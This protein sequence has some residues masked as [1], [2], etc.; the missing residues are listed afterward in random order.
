MKKIIILLF[1]PALLFISKSYCQNNNAFEISKNLEI[2]ADVFKQLNNNYV[3]EIKPG[4]LTKTAIDA[5]LETLDPYTVYKSES[6][7]EDFRFM[8]TGQYGG[9]GALIQKHD[10]FVVISEPYKNF[11]ADKAGIKAGDKIL[12][13][14]GHDAKNLSTSEVSEMLKGQPG[15]EFILCV[16]RYGEEKPLNIPVNREK[17]QIDDIPYYGMANDHI[18][19]I[20]LS[21]FTQHAASHVKNAFL[22]LKSNN[23]LE[24]IIL[25]LRG[26][27][28]G[29]LNEAV[30]LVNIWVDK[31][32]LI[33]STKGRLPEKSKDHFTRM[34]VIDP[35]IPVAV[36]VNG[37]SASASEIVAGAI[38]DL[39]RGVIVGSK[40]YGKGLVQNIV[41]L[42]YNAQIK[43]T[44]AKYYIP[45]GRCIQA[46][47]YSHNGTAGPTKI[48]DSLFNEFKTRNGRKVY[49]GGGVI[50]DLLSEERTVHDITMSLLSKHLIF[51]F[52]TAYYWNKQDVPGP[53]EFEITDEMYAEFVSFL[54]DKNFT[55]K[56][57]S[58]QIL[59][60]LKEASLEEK[61]YD[62]IKEELD[63]LETALSHD[64]KSDL[65]KF[66]DEISEFIRIEITPRYFYQAGMMEANLVH[67]PEVKQAI[68]ILQDKTKYKTILHQK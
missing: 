10:D 21:S 18:G 31:G 2:Y 13:I 19:Y 36:L 45:S 62:A 56:T 30:D 67:D 49:D 17:I 61:Y 7:I 28:G 43:I 44:V 33:V 52:C 59:K 48:A 63:A 24:G 41:P 46:I 64:K 20:S 39:D 15:T 1:V 54:A 29:L 51:D 27:G 5:F 55:Y 34:S 32:D 57:Q 25:D 37:G 50:P 42:S 66:R 4:E 60:D 11:P 22:D 23:E 65:N 9:I 53:R 14:D 58:E 35:D 26:N 6:E 47:D 40:T 3:D 16:E 8:T 12:K 68:E 38:Q